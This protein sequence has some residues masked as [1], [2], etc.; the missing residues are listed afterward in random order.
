[1][2]RSA[3]LLCSL[4][5][6]ALTSCGGKMTPP[7][8][9]S[10]FISLNGNFSFTGASQ[11]FSPNMI[12]IGGPLQ[13]DSTG[14]VSGMLGISNS[15]SNCITAGTVSAFTG[16]IDSMN[17]LTLT[18]APING[19]V[20]SFTATAR[21]NE[22]FASGTYTVAGGCLAGDH[23]SL[24]AQHLLTGSYTGSVL[25]NGSPINVTLN[26][27]PP[28]SPDATGAYSIQAS[29]TF[30]NT[31]ACGGFTSL[32]TE[33]G[34]QAGLMVSFKMAAGASPVLSFSGTTIDGTA[35]MLSGTL[36]ITGGPCDQ[37]KG[38]L[39]LSK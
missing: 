5:L 20:I 37:L 32:S 30:S 4:G 12:F 6:L 21:P 17:L 23:G 15:V 34:S 39:N 2:K 13:T 33:G 28:G 24:Q 10:P 1:M 19:Q 25:I 7:V 35:N 3:L 29:G 31:V 9:T 26:F 16:M 27:A 11:A 8:V 18:S 36:G 38:T 22:T 14:H